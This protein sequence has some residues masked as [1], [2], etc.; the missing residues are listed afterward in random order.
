MMNIDLLH[1][2]YTPTP[3]NQAAK[4]ID[5]TMNRTYPPVRNRLRAHHELVQN[6]LRASS[7]FSI[8]TRVC[9][10]SRRQIH[11]Y[12]PFLQRMSLVHLASCIFKQILSCLG[13]A[14]SPLRATCVFAKTHSHH[15]DLFLEILRWH[16]ANSMLLASAQAFH[17]QCLDVLGK[18]PLRCSVC[19]IKARN[20]Q[21]Y[22][23]FR[24]LSN[25]LRDGV[26]YLCSD[27][28]FCESKLFLTGADGL[29]SQA[30]SGTRD[31]IRLGVAIL[32]RLRMPRGGFANTFLASLRD[33]V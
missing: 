13:P 6:F 26:I 23:Y 27:C 5:F 8:H 30:S 3:R 4:S 1:N 33:V 14:F 20:R 12:F 10:F 19:Q 25:G 18:I 24:L 31:Q 29:L 17:R 2:R 15:V 7:K 9:S 28:V 22:R 16:C 11:H 32:R 21:M